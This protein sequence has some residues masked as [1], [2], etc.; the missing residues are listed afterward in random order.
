[1]PRTKELSHAAVFISSG[2]RQVLTWCSLLC[3]TTAIEGQGNS[4]IKE[5]DKAVDCSTLSA[6]HEQHDAGQQLLLDHYGARYPGIGCFALIWQQILARGTWL[7][8]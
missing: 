3:A 1:M 5:A 2:H 7:M 6:M 8:L 4:S